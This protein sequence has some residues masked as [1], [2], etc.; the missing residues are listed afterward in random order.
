[1]QLGFYL[2]HFIEKY[3][4][5]IFSVLI[6]VD[7][8]CCIFVNIMYIGRDCL[9]INIKAQLTLI[10]S[11]FSIPIYYLSFFFRAPC[12]LAQFAKALRSSCLI[13]FGKGLM[14]ERDRIWSVGS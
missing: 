2:P 3:G 13:F 12:S 14:K 8:M 1:M 10:R 6:C 7:R 5:Y 9:M 4:D 11:V